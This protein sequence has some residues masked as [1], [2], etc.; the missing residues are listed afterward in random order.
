[1]TFEEL[2]IN[3]TAIAGT[4]IGAI[5]GALFIQGG[6]SHMKQIWEQID[7]DDLIM[8]NQPLAE[9][10]RFLD[11]KNI[12]SIVKDIAKDKKINLTP[13]KLLLKA[14][15]KEWQ[16]RISPI[17]F[18]LLMCCTPTLKTK[19]VFLKDIPR[20]KLINYLLASSSFLPANIYIDDE[21]MLDGCYRVN[22]PYKMLE[23]KN[24]PLIIVDVSGR[25]KKQ[26]EYEKEGLEVI[27]VTPQ[28]KLGSFFELDH[29]VHQ[30]FEQQGYEDMLNAYANY[31]KQKVLV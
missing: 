14:N 19:E 1:M 31:Q 15:I 8:F 11:P 20:N 3:I 30:K 12:K 25:P 4:S 28:E 23:S 26:K 7:I 24:I 27:L 17:D 21:L 18:G 10:E 2:N 29:K 9:R 16:I 13:L 6:Y 5:N 22:V